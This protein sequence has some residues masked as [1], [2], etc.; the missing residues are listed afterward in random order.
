MDIIALILIT[1]NV[2]IV[3][4]VPEFVPLTNCRKIQIQKVLHALRLR[5]QTT[6]FYL[7][8]PAE[9]H[10]LFWRMQLLPKTELWLE[11]HGKMILQ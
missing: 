5:L 2:Q 11:Q 1:K 8:V 4:C 10:F 9:G 6:M 7:Q 3:D